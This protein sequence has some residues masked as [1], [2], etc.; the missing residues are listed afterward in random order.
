[1]NTIYQAYP[2]GYSWICNRL[3]IDAASLSREYSAVFDYSAYRNSTVT[4]PGYIKYYS[5]DLDKSLYDSFGL[6]Q[7]LLFALG[8]EEFIPYILKSA[9]INLTSNEVNMLCHMLEEKPGSVLLRK[10]GYLYETFTGHEISYSCEEELAKSKRAVVKLLSDDKYYTLHKFFEDKYCA[11][12]GIYD[13]TLGPLNILSPIIK[14]TEVLVGHENRPYGR[15]LYN[16]FVEASNDKEIAELISDK[17]YIKE[18]QMSF[19]IEGDTRDADRIAKYNAMLKKYKYGIPGLNKKSVIDMQNV[20]VQ[21][22]DFTGDYREIQNFI[23]HGGRADKYPIVDY[24][25]P[26]PEDVRELM[27]GLYKMHRY[28]SEDESIDPIVAGSA[29]HLAFTAIHPL[30]DGNGRIS[31]TL[32]HDQIARHKYVPSGLIFPVSD[33]IAHER[34]GYEEALDKVTGNIIRQCK[35]SFNDD[36]KLNVVG[37]YADLYRYLD[38]TP[39]TEYLY[40]AIAKTLDITVKDIMKDCRF[41]YEASKI[42]SDIYPMKPKEKK[43]FLNAVSAESG[44]LS[45]R[46]Q[47]RLRKSIPEDSLNV[48]MGK[49]GNLYQEIV[50]DD[51][52]DKDVANNDDIGKIQETESHKYEKPKQE[53]F[54]EQ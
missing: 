53:Y 26:A 32:L 47:K 50:S 35:Y 37:N 23:G 44:V 16:A 8:K 9:F 54:L 1:M 41:R 27:S 38:A 22:D 42:I 18:S 49:I 39:F 15:R 17:M 52:K 21:Q 25:P 40:G 4:L 2:I 24:I 28:L 12:F 20:I 5:Q 33:I 3:N 34:R 14:R 19:K 43:I 45:G 30:S 29:M 36:G 51:S 31:R 7:H 10:A 48:L 13:N 46:M 6:L 11:K